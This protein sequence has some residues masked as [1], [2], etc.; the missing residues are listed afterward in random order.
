MTSQTFWVRTM[1]AIIA[2][3]HAMPRHI[4]PNDDAGLVVGED[5]PLILGG[6]G[7]GGRESPL[8]YDPLAV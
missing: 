8:Q 1:S 3:S 6:G 7:G 4:T 5:M 2:L